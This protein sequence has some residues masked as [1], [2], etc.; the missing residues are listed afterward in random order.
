MDGNN[1]A[2]QMDHAGHADRCI[3]PSTYMIS[4]ADIDTFKND[5]HMQPGQHGNT[6]YHH[7][8][9]CADTW[10]ATSTVDEDTVK[11]FKQTSIFISACRHGIILM[12][13]EMLRSG[14]LY[15]FECNIKFI[16]TDCVFIVPSMPW[17]Q[18]TNLFA[19]T[20]MIK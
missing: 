8:G 14:E 9:G 17:Q 1:S 20:V 19:C 16:V 11:V 5:V 3:F 13:A 6:E 7:D 15:M 10:Q 2:K 4:R 18:S 12:C